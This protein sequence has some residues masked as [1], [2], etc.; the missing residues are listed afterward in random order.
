MKNT[1]KDKIIIATGGTGGHIFPAYGLANYFNKND[2]VVE[3]ITDK[4]GLKYLNKHKDIKLILNNSATIFKKNILDLVVSIFII[5]FSYI[6]S[7]V[8][9][10]KAKPIIV[11]GMGGHASFPACLAAKTL[12]IPFIIYENN[13]Q[14]GKSNKYLLPFAYKIFVSYEDLAGIKNKHKHKVIVTGNIIREEILNFKK[15]FQFMPDILNILVLG[16][17]QAAKSFGELLPKVFEQC[18][19]ENINIKIFQ[20]CIE[21]QTEALNEIY[22][23]LNFNF[24]LF[25]FTN[26]ITEY[27]SKTELVITRSGSSVTSELINCR[28]PFI[29]IPYPHATDSHQDKNAAY[30]EKKGYG[31]LVKE[32]HVHEKLFPL[33]KSLY[34][35]RKLLNK[36][37]EKQKKHSDKKVFLKIN[38]VIEILKNE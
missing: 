26:N 5:F 7:L 30:F 14:I 12:N 13:I 28:I 32:A 18:M 27:F 37:I 21:S 17:S 35:D 24:E 25:N 11:F 16:G 3:I 38:R 2:Y 8:I 33:I 9:L 6:K 29:S 19:R 31:L 23:K 4:R 34:K 20:Q 10:Y 1:N 22:K 36:I 15:D